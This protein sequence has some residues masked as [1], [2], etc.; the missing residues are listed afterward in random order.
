[1]RSARLRRSATCKLRSRVGQHLPSRTWLAVFAILFQAI[2]FGWHS[3]SLQFGNAGGEPRLAIAKKAVPTSD[4]V[5]DE[6]DCQICAGLHHLSATPVQFVAL[7]PPPHSEAI[8]EN[9]SPIIAARIA[10]GFNARAPPE[11]I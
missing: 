4:T 10:A 11:T 2:L 1:M 8:A 3:H 5:D 9:G 7:P 6:R